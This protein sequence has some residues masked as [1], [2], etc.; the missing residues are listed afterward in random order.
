M[1]R[2]WPK[3]SVSVQEQKTERAR[4]QVVLGQDLSE[5]DAEALRQRAVASGLPRDTYIK[6]LKR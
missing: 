1:V 2:R 6:K 3:F 4:Y 5:A